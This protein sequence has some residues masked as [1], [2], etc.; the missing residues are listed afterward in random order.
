M[1]ATLIEP[2]PMTP[3]TRTRS[4]V[5]S[6]ATKVPTP[7]YA[8]V[9]TPHGP[10]VV[11]EA[12][13]GTLR[14]EWRSITE[15]PREAKHDAALR[16][17]LV[18]RLRRYFAGERVSFDDIPLPAHGGDFTRRC[19][20]ACRAIPPGETIS[21]LELA[22]RAGQERAARAAGQAMRRN[23]L[24]VIVPCHR[25]VGSNGSLHGYA[26]S[27]EAAGSPLATKAWLLNLERGSA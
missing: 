8:V 1:L 10:F 19:W 27:R 26:G 7:R 11:I 13:D 21:Y 18:S 16:P 17:N 12:V 24:P 9:E 5:I 6:A 22:R 14:A 15:L 2:K 3:S 23:P 20:E 4:N 25:V